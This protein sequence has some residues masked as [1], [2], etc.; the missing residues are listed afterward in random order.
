VRRWRKV[1][2]GA[3]AAL[4]ASGA[5]AQVSGSVSVLSDYRFRGVSFS[6]GD[7]AVQVD[8]NYDAANGGYAGALA[9]NVKFDTYP[10]LNRQVLAY[11]GYARRIGPEFGVD[12]GASY[13]A[14]AAG[15]DFDYLEVHA[16]VTAR[17]INVLIAFAPRY[18]GQG[19]ATYVELNGGAELCPSLR[20]FGHVGVLY[21]RPEAAR[22]NSSMHADGRLGL[23]FERQGFS[24]QLSRVAVSRV[25]DIYPGGATGDRSAWV[26][27][28]TQ[29]F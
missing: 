20:L 7:P 5:A 12:A 2:A 25:S 11:G 21:A 10:G 4:L 13:A 14:F 16:G 6:A 9:S 28:A 24:A 3:V 19:S 17:A 8:A 29:S 26:L 23:R 18:F 22:R 27:Q 1:F 15:G